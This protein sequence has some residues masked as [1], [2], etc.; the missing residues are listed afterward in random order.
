MPKGTEKSK[1]RFDWVRFIIYFFIAAIAA[2]GI[3]MRAI[4]AFGNILSG[5]GLWLL[6]EA[7]IVWGLYK[8]DN[9]RRY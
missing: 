1:S 6:I 4:Y 9:G 2:T 7:I 3:T 8:I 5:I